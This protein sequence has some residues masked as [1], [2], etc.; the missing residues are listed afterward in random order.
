MQESKVKHFLRIVLV[1]VHKHFSMWLS[2]SLFFIAFF[3]EQKVAGTIIRHVFGMNHIN[4]EEYESAMHSRTIDLQ[5]L[6]IF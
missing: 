2:N 6:K 1:S 5:R 3:G 4:N